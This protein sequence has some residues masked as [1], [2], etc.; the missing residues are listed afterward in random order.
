MT[1]ILLA[2]IAIEIG[3]AITFVAVKNGLLFSEKR[4]RLTQLINQQQQDIL[5]NELTLNFL[6]EHEE[7]RINNIIE[8]NQ[9]RYDR[10]KARLSTGHNDERTKINLERVEEII[11]TAKASLRTTQVHA[12]KLDATNKLLRAKNE[13]L[14]RIKTKLKTVPS[15]Y[16]VESVETDSTPEDE[17]VTKDAINTE[18]GAS[19]IGTA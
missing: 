17:A 11:D 3:T 2:I 9:Q 6:K 1:I 16:E 4:R 10:M 19:K 7:K 8:Y 13:F 15:S 12:E 18:S 14:N 5:D